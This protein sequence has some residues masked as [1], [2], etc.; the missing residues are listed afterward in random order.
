[1]ESVDH[2]IPETENELKR[3]LLSEVMSRFLRRAQFG[4]RIRDRYSN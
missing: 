3:I 1:M 4:D 2:S